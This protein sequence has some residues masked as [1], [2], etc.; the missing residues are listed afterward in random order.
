M[1]FYLVHELDNSLLAITD[2]EKLARS[3]QTREE[4]IK[5]DETVEI[6]TGSFD[7]FEE[8]YYYSIIAIWV[9]LCITAFYAV[10]AKLVDLLLG[11][12]QWKHIT[13]LYV[14]ITV[15]VAATRKRP[16]E[17]IMMI[18]TLSIM[19]GVISGSVTRLIGAL[20]SLGAIL[21][22]FVLH[23]WENI[24]DRTEVRWVLIGLLLDLVYLGTA[25]LISQV[26]KLGLKSI[27]LVLV[28]LAAECAIF[29]LGVHIIFIDG[30]WTRFVAIISPVSNFLQSFTRYSAQL[31]LFYLNRCAR[32]ILAATFTPRLP[33]IGTS[34]FLANLRNELYSTSLPNNTSYGPGISSYAYQGLQGRDTIRLLLIRK[35]SPSQELECNFKVVQL[36]SPEAYEAVSYVWGHPS[37]THSILVD[38]RRLAITKSAYDIIHRRRSAL[39]DQCIWIDRIC[40]NQGDMVEK[41]SQVLM[42]GDIYKGAARVIAY[43]GDSENAH[44]VQLL[45]A[46]LHFMKHGIGLPAAVMKSLSF[47]WFQRPKWDALIE[48]FGNKW[49]RRVWIVSIS[50]RN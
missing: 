39:I 34:E 29:C 37:A 18:A 26:D 12:L 17:L 32:Y 11:P 2:L 43:L 1:L 33:R 5:K 24:S 3:R 40:I 36:G 22:P 41:A 16:V 13:A 47:I 50:S 49:F 42:M 4:Q 7:T 20:F 45:F 28:V 48:F 15:S 35:G 10:F 8:A 46:E 21:W 44:L 9:Y 31:L 38:G 27:G 30:P 23:T 14:M 6:R 19:P 25:R